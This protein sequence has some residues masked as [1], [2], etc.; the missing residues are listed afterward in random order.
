MFR[1]LSLRVS[2]G[3]LSLQK[4]EKKEKERKKI[5]L[6]ENRRRSARQGDFKGNRV[7]KA[8]KKIVNPTLATLTAA[9]V[10]A[11]DSKQCRR[12]I[13]CND[14]DVALARAFFIFPPLL[15]VMRAPH[16]LRT[17]LCSAIRTSKP[18]SRAPEPARCQEQG[19]SGWAPERSTA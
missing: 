19:A 13:M 4:E 14:Q 8:K 1:A 3:I 17:A 11:G 15:S 7:Y 16:A 10:H 9:T 18:T 2:A 5:K 12:R 6:K